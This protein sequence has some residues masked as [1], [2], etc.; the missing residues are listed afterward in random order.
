MNIKI[1]TAVTS[2]LASVILATGLLVGHVA[3]AQPAKVEWKCYT[4]LAATTDPVYKRLLDLAD[5]IKR[6]TNGAIQ[7]NCNIGGSIPIKTSTMV[8]AVSD[9]VLQFGMADSGSYSGFIQLSGITSL[10]GL[11]SSDDE[12][13]K[14]FAAVA[15]MLDSSLAK[16]GVK[17]LGEVHYP[18][19]VFWG[20]GP[21]T[22][23]QDLANKKIRVTTPEQA[24]FAKRI[25]A[26]PVTIGTPEVS[27]ALQS[28]LIQAALTASAGGGRL[29]K[30]HFKSN[31]RVGPNYVTVL[32]VANKSGFDALPADVQGKVAARVRRAGQEMTEM[33]ARDEEQLT[34]EFAKGGMTI[35]RGKPEDFKWIEERMRSY[36]PEWAKAKGPE[37][38]E[39]LRLIRETL[40]KK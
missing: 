17:L 32:L 1:G 36:W 28:G 30:E 40:N 29:W 38:E 33:L 2:L 14:G 10:P 18:R 19:Q 25:G 15:S 3:Q 39:A 35:T 9:N 11:F 5:E 6:D 8:Q 21:I 16:K 31:F 12:L 27:S 4:Y 20:V 22:S 37:A 23:M 13:Q 26:L 7:M 24:E 34:Q